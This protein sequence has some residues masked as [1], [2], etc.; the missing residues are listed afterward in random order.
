MNNKVP[1]AV[2]SPARTM[3]KRVVVSGEQR[4]VRKSAPRRIVEEKSRQHAAAVPYALSPDNIDPEI[5]VDGTTQV[6]V[7]VLQE[8]TIVAKR[9]WAVVKGFRRGVSDNM[10]ECLQ[11]RYYKQLYESVLKRL[12]PR[13]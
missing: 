3:V 5:L 9:D 13:D 12:T 8:R 4:V 7:K 11:A 2:C 10:R 6:R 1:P